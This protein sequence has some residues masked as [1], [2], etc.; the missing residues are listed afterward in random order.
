MVCLTGLA[1]L[2]VLCSESNGVDW[3]KLEFLE[4][5]SNDFELSEL[6]YSE[7]YNHSSCFRKV[8]FIPFT[9]L[10]QCYTFSFYLKEQSCYFYSFNA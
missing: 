5:W 2:W 9:L 10:V 4:R 3:I 7:S 1:N 6:C 8:Y